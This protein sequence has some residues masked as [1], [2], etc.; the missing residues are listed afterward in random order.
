MWLVVLLFV[1]GIVVIL[2]E[3]FLPGGMLGVLGGGL[4]IASVIV[5]W[6]RFPQYGPIILG[7]EFA[8][9]VFS[10]VLGLYLLSHT[11][12]GNH[13]VLQ[14]AQPSDEGYTSPSED[15]ALV[16][17]M[18]QVQTALRPA[19]SIVVDGRRID[20]VSDGTFIETG[21]TVRI[22]EV[23]GHRVVCEDASVGEEA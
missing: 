9:V 16:G 13:L 10:V 2:A 21:T 11:R 5:G 14:T 23:E 17:Q 20:A 1:A 4:V 18:A 6:M 19:G 7:V 8:G 3:F 12:L 15:V 22:V